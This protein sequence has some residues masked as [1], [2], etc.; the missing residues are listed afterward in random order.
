MLMTSN[1]ADATGAACDMCDS[2]SV[3]AYFCEL[4]DGTRLCLPHLAGRWR[5]TK[6]P[7]TRAQLR[8]LILIWSVRSVR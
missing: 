1:L 6:D 8:R 2:E 7:L 5:R 3:A 4:S